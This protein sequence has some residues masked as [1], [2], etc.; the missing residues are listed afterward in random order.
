[1]AEI[2]LAALAILAGVICAAF[3]LLSA[4]ANA[5]VAATNPSMVNHKTTVIFAVLALA[6]IAGGVFML[7]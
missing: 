7:N 1:M 3:A 2:I 6:G 5:H 4:G